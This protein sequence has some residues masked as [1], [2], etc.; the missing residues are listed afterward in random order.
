MMES[1]EMIKELLG[2][3][4]TEETITEAVRERVN[5]L[6]NYKLSEEIERIAKNYAEEKGTTYIREKVDEVLEKPVKKDDGWGKPIYYDSF[7]EFV[8][9]NIAKLIKEDYRFRSELERTVQKRM[10]GILKKVSADISEKVI[11]DAALAEMA[12]ENS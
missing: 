2:E 5:D 3:L 6:F 7:E 1:R 12:K 8:K 4:I 11:I 9:A 10:D